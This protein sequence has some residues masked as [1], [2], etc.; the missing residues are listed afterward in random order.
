M[1][2]SGEAV[3]ADGP[4]ISLGIAILSAQDSAEF[5]LGSPQVGEAFPKQGS[6]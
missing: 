4:L 6:G 5:A 2:L 1:G 3:R